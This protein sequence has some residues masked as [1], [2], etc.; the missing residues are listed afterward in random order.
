MVRMLTFGNLKVWLFVQQLQ[1]YGDDTPSSTILAS[2]ECI[3][4]FKFME[5]TTIF[6]G[7]MIRDTAT[8]APKIFRSGDEAEAYAATYIEKRFQLQK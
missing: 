5:P 2:G 7:E 3:C 8:G 4:Y 1:Q 6:L